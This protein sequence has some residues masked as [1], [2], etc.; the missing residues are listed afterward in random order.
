M[1]T[2]DF[3]SN[4]GLFK[5]KF[6]LDWTYKLADKQTYRFTPKNGASDFNIS[7]LDE[8]ARDV[9]NKISNNPK[10]TKRQFS[11]IQVFELSI[12]NNQKFNSVIW[13][14]ERDNNL[15]LGSYTYFA[16]SKGTDGY[17]NE[18]K[19]IADIIGSLKIIEP[20]KREQRIA[21]F[22]FGKFTESIAAADELY[23]RAAE[24]GCFIECVCLLANLIDGRL[25]IANILYDQIQNNESKMN[26]SLVYQ[27]ENDKKITEKDIYD[28]SKNK[29][30]INQSIYDDLF[31]AYNKRNR[32]I[33]RYIISEITTS[34]IL[35]IAVEYLDIHRK[36]WQ[37]V[38][39]LETKQMELGI[40]MTATVEEFPKKDIEEMELVIKAAL[41]KK[42]GGI[43]F[44]N[45]PL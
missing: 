22:R 24:K 19:S 18:I 7:T 21:W 3:I 23:M 33:H 10:S 9:F 43:D 39:D 44:N 31:K 8:R 12:E 28:L 20:D 13:Y 40:G 30:I 36:I 16:N 42:H 15:F 6:P 35:E 26:L 45:L 34:D 27:G 32:V 2:H 4:D 41:Q 17:N 5:L 29:S 1:A 14:F 37:I 38:Y 25:R 11:T